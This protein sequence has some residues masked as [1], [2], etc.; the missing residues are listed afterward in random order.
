MQGQQM[1]SRVQQMQENM[2]SG[3]HQ[4]GCKEEGGENQMEQINRHWQAAALQMFFWLRQPDLPS[5]K[6]T[7]IFPARKHDLARQQVSHFAGCKSL[8]W[9]HKIYEKA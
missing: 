3:R 1:W 4:T 7:A 2:Q 8:K 5:R 9:G 6:S